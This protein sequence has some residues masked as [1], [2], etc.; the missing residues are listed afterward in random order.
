MSHP[1][2]PHLPRAVVTVVPPGP[3]R[4]EDLYHFMPIG[5]MIAKGTIKGRQLKNQIEAAADGSL[6][7]DVSK[8][9]GGWLFNFSGAMMDLDPFA[10]T[11]ER[12]RYPNLRRS[13]E[14]LAPSR[15]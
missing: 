6:N 9:T 11:G 7:P 2:T 5:P 1:A 12:A 8:W 13:G 14:R 4:L 3:I 10:K 15:S